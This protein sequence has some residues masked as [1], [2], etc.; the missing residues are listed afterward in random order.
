MA[1]FL[2]VFVGCPCRSGSPD[3]YC[4][5]SGSAFACVW[6]R[7]PAHF[8]RV[9]LTSFEARKCLIVDDEPAI[10]DYLAAVA[11]DA[12]W[13]AEATHSSD[14]FG[15][16]FQED[17]P[18]L[19]VTDLSMPCRDGVEIM[20]WLA[21]MSYGGQIL[22]ISACDLSIIRASTDVGRLYGL[23]ICGFAQ[24]PIAASEFEA[25]LRKAHSPHV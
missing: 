10:A 4:E 6:E 15:A 21:Q 1:R 7:G 2:P 23:S 14:A 9:S 8:R 5:R 19:V 11:I 3:S 13:K 25:L 22:V 18:D 20:R 17:H 16:A 24:K 12:G